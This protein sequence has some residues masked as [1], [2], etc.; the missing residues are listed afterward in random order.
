LQSKAPIAAA[1]LLGQ[2][3]TP[4]T[5]KDLGEQFADWC[6]GLD[7]SG[8]GGGDLEIWNMVLRKAKDRICEKRGQTRG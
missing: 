8:L 1:R 6:L 3:K 4:Q 5:V 2:G 7:E